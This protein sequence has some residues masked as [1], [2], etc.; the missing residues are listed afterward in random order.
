MRSKASSSVTSACIFSMKTR[1]P[2]VTLHL[3]GNRKCAF[4]GDAV[5]L[6]FSH[7]SRP[8][9]YLAGKLVPTWAIK[10]AARTRP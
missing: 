7:P 10:P 8:R 3:H 9:A 1:S 5:T 2:G 4:V 6:H